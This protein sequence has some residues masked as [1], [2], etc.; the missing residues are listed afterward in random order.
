M[1]TATRTKRKVTADPG[2]VRAGATVR[3]KAEGSLPHHAYHARGLFGIADRWL[4]PYGWRVVFPL[5]RC[6]CLIPEH[7]LEA[8]SG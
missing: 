8:V 6:E 7:M 1:V 4:E 2:G 3:V 5:D